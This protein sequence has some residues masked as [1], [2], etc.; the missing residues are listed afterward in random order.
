M[1]KLL[2]HLSLYQ[3][4]GAVAARCAEDHTLIHSEVPVYAIIIGVMTTALGADHLVCSQVCKGRGCCP[5]LLCVA[6]GRGL[7][8]AAS[9]TFQQDYTVLKPLISLIGTSQIRG[10]CAP[11]LIKSLATTDPS[12][13][14]LRRCI[15]QEPTGV[16]LYG[17]MRLRCCNRQEPTELK[18]Y[19]RMDCWLMTVTFCCGCISAVYL[20]QQALCAQFPQNP[21]TPPLPPFS[22]PPSPPPFCPSPHCPPPLDNPPSPRV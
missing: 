9:K 19:G 1:M 8:R 12:K 10:F 4:P 21:Q 20:M 14:V 5:E 2:E 11:H 7:D 22:A 3:T 15:R 6:A 13:G 16:I 18:V 17:R